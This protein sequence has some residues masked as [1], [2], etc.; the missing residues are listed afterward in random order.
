VRQN[1]KSGRSV[2]LC[3]T[4]GLLALAARTESQAP[5]PSAATQTPS[6]RGGVE[7]V[8]VEASV[9]DKAG[10]TVRGLTPG[11]FRIEIGGSAREV[12]SA[13]LI[14]HRPA[15]AGARYDDLTSN[16]LAG[17]G[18]TVL[19]LVDQTSLRSES[20]AV[21]KR[22]ERWL[23]TLGPNDRV[24]FSA[25]PT[26]NSIDFTTDHG[27]IRKA[28]GSALLAPDARAPI[29]SLRNVSVWEG[30][31]IYNGNLFVRNE[32]IARECRGEE[33]TC[34]NEIEMASRDIWMDSQ[35]RVQA[36][37]GGFHGLMRGMRALP[38]I[39]HVVLL[40]SGWPI[41]ERTAASEVPVIGAE[42]AL[43]N[44]IIHTFTS[45]AWALSAALSQPSQSIMQ[46]Q[47]LLLSSVEML[48]GITGG[49]AARLVGDGEAA[50]KDLD[51]TISSYYRLG[52]K[53]APE[54]LDGK[55]RQISLKVTRPG[56]SLR[57]YRKVLAGNRAAPALT[58]AD[59]TAALRAAVESPAI[60]TG[61]DLRAT[62]YVL[63]GEATEPGSVRVV[64]VGDIARGA[65]G[66][67]TS[68]AVLYDQNGRPVGNEGQDLEVTA[69]R[70]RF[71]AALSVS[72]GL[73]RARIAVR[74]AEGRIG[75]VE[76]AVDARWQSA[77][78]VETTGL[79]LL[80]AAPTGNV[81]EPVLETVSTADRVVAQ[82][83][84]RGASAE[85]HSAVPIEI[86]QGGSG[87][88]L[89]RVHARVARTTAGTLVAQESIP[90][91]LL[92]PGRY[93]I[94]AAFPDAPLRFSRTLLVEPAL[95]A[96]GAPRGSA[97]VSLA[98]PPRF[99][100]REVLDPEVVAPML[101]RL[102]AR[103]DTAAAR[104]AIERVK[105]GPWPAE[106]LTGP[107]QSS[108]L[109]SA[110]IGGLGQ[111]QR[112]D[113]DVAAVSFRHA[114][115][116]A[117]DFT[118]SI[119]YLGA[120]YAAGARDREA[121]GAWQ[122][123][124][125]RERTM[126]MLSLLAIEAWLR[127]GRPAAAQALAADA[128]TRWPA[129]ATFVRLNAQAA[130]AAGHRDEGLALVSQLPDPDAP[131]LLMAMAVLYEAA[132]DQAPVWDVARD[133]AAMLKF[134]DAYARVNGPSMALVDAWT[135]KP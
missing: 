75:S 56:V 30:L 126:P 100:L 114:L 79:V 1:S 39:K 47:N 23:T 110:F 76:R 87:D 45:E 48:S 102:A 8:V 29:V 116:V 50:F 98:R 78:A 127:A 52:I 10:G 119:L 108:P 25:L 21:L 60:V 55:P 42:A 12:V 120:C 71:Q 19:L 20:R 117:P 130:L 107:L 18:R 26:G 77:G 68:L 66:L 103:P 101:E 17:L 132:R 35:F 109:A 94:S 112:G 13:D 93:T 5:Q 59:P 122:T 3:A 51:R 96:G 89:L 99:E 58:S 86:G 62:A 74:D 84:L 65:P 131:M 31:N 73:Y 129:D 124:L 9:L 125:A 37:L 113:L 95:P 82:L 44:V 43:S 22:A 4:L 106:I 80:V 115:R 15:S 53:P 121:A 36:V 64:L 133:E 16:D 49:L 83:S 111:L 72:P 63:H 24:G 135:R 104:D 70:T 92:P 85:A 97:A 123:A 40:S 7:I 27:Q 41:D 28:L 134:R 54:D 81:A 38:G 6:F 34:P 61:L 14:E 2:V 67:A 90:V 88:V 57:S 32:V 128:R 33:R 91:G 11:D 46:D 105:R 69:S 118:P